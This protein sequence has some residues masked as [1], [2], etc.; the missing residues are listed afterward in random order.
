MSTSATQLQSPPV[1]FPTASQTS[2]AHASPKRVKLSFSDVANLFVRLRRFSTRAGVSP[3]SS[4]AASKDKEAANS[5]SLK[6]HI[7]RERAAAPPPA[8][9]ISS[10]STSTP[11]SRIK[12]RRRSSYMAPQF[13]GPYAY[14][15]RVSA[16]RV[17]NP[18][19]PGHISCSSGDPQTHPCL[20]QG[21][22]LQDVPLFGT[23]SPEDVQNNNVGGTGSQAVETWDIYEVADGVNLDLLLRRTRIRMVEYV[24]S[25]GANVLTEERYVLAVLSSCHLSSNRFYRWQS[26]ICGPKKGVYRVQVSPPFLSLSALRLSISP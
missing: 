3:K 17:F 4:A 14:T 7:S 15:R 6:L 18:S 5:S 23:E 24:N 8:L 16:P 13:V 12:I 1:A 25:L 11:R 20:E 26:T 2:E 22:A 10:P 19:K 9:T 21:A